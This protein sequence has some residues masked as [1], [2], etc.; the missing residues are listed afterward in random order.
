MVGRERE[1]IWPVSKIFPLDTTTFDQI[2]AKSL[3]CLAVIIIQGLRREQRASLGPTGMTSEFFLFLVLEGMH[4]W[5]RKRC[6]T[7]DHMSNFRLVSRWQIVRYPIICA[8]RCAKVTSL[9][10]CDY[11]STVLCCTSALWLQSPRPEEEPRAV[12]STIRSVR[13]IKSQ[14]TLVLCLF[15]ALYV[16]WES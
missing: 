14:Q 9:E 15:L 6:T 7:C 11:M 12:A 4:S 3:P 10:H 13:I 8:S 2:L 1:V 5:S 16:L